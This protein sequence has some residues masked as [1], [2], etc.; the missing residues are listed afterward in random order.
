VFI[1]LSRKA[2]A[3]GFLETATDGHG[4]K[5]QSQTMLGCGLLALNLIHAEA[6]RSLRGGEKPLIN[7]NRR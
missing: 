3:S 6:R 2:L 7:A 1:P 4:R 5:A